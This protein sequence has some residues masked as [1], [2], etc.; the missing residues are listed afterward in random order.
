MESKIRSAV[1]NEFAKLKEYFDYT[2]TGLTNA[3][4]TDR[5]NNYRA[6]INAVAPEY[7]D[8][9]DWVVW[10]AE[11]GARTSDEVKALYSKA[12]SVID[13]LATKAEL[14]AQKK[15]VEEQIAALPT[16]ITSADKDAVVAAKEAADAYK[17]T[18]R[19]DI[20]NEATLNLAVKALADSLQKDIKAAVKALPTA[21]KVTIADKEAVKAV[22]ELIDTYNTLNDEYEVFEGMYADT[23][24]SVA[25]Q[26]RKIKELEA[27]AVVDAVNAL[28]LNITLADKA[29]VEAAR[30][31]YDAYVAE[32]TDYYEPHDARTDFADTV[33]KELKAA[34]EAIKLAMA[35]NAKSVEALKLTA[36]S[37][38]TKGA[39][40][41][42]WTV[43]GDASA[44]QGYE[45]WKSTKKNSGYKKMFTTTKLTYKNTKG[46]KKGT[47]YYY[48][49]R[50]IAYDVDG[51]KVTSDWSNKAY[52]IAK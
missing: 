8:A 14:D 12:V 11:Q 7:V 9:E 3:E 35:E 51:K 39:I 19:N 49:V 28:P 30:K 36:S 4:K 52:R 13:G 1:T 37:K 43:K 25:D 41:V 18:G 17:A 31:A 32:Y 2:Q 15:A 26:L 47:R 22:D 45:I 38:A 27:K 40:T 50:A 33:A 46:L 24:Y 48:K 10:Y 21:A 6:V 20:A 34:E 16:T 5:L 23:Q 42:K 29:A 44:V